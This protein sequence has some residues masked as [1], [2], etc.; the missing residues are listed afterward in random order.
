MKNLHKAFTDR[1][2]A[3]NSKKEVTAVTRSVQ[4]PG[5]ENSI[6][7]TAV[8]IFA[9]RNTEGKVAL[10]I[11]TK[12]VWLQNELDEQVPSLRDMLQ[13]ELA[14][15]DKE[16]KLFQDVIKTYLLSVNAE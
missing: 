9:E 11:I 8:T 3:V 13:S 16:V 2:G 5:R 1:V 6:E 12:Y 10:L 14:L 7:H 4:Q 15:I